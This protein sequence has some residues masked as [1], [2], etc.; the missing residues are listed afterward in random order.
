MRKD[1]EGYPMGKVQCGLTRHHLS[2]E[3]A[4]ASLLV[5]SKLC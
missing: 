2:Q 5:F 3:N 1:N 4:A